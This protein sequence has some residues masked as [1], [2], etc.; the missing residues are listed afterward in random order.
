[1]KELGV[2]VIVTAYDRTD[3]VKQAIDSILH[4]EMDYYS[5]E[6]IVVSNFKIDLNPNKRG[7][8]VCNIVMEGS[9]GEFLY[10]GINAAKYEIITFLDDDDLYEPEKL[11]RVV[12][13]FSRNP[14]LSYYHNNQRYVNTN[15][16]PT[17]YIRLVENRSRLYLEQDIWVNLGPKSNAIKHA[18][19]AGG[20]FNLSSIAITREGVNKYLPLLK[21][22]KGSTDAFFFLMTLATEGN[23]FLDHKRLTIYRIHSSNVSGKRDF[24]LK[25]SEL[26]KQIN[27]FNLILEFL[28]E[29]HLP[30][31]MKIYLEKWIYLYKYEYELMSLVFGNSHRKQLLRSMKK[32]L[33][34][35]KEHSNTLKNRILLF[36]ILGIVNTNFARLIYLIANKP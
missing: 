17:D 9:V 18:I 28:N 29:R 27:T 36:A 26:Q 22:I 12:D 6:V 20:D 2:S 13:V 30:M 15:L 19:A 24:A 1:M 31:N 7:I 5:I 21:Q 4:Q 10:A 33:S 8:E 32:I 34:L 25:A 3:F 23:M 11:H 14:V 35:G 16:Q